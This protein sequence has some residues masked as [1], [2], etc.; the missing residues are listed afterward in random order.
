M[1]LDSLIAHPLELIGIAASILICA[2]LCMTHI[3]SLRIINLLGS[4]TFIVYGLFIVPSLSILITNAFSAAVNIFYLIKM[5]SETNRADIFDILFVN[6]E[7]DELVRR[8]VLFHND[9]IV[10]FFPSF[11]SNPQ[12][13]SLVG[14]ECCFILRE[15]LPVSLV[16][17]KRG[18]DDEINII[19]DY[20]V[21]AFR[22]FKNAKFFFDNMVNRVATPGTVFVAS[23][24]I[25][26]HISYLKKI[27]F[28]ETGKQGDRV[29]FRRAV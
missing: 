7:E 17:Y 24:D 27:G 28:T 21:P 2:S 9:D 1:Q 23:T 4:L 5:L 29:Y 14:A 13:G 26:K 25:P 20:A 18:E 19:L 12:T 10:K 6:P 8:F 15:T 16:A 3:K 11:D 22:D